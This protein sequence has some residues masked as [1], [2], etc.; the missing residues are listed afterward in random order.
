MLVVKTFITITTTIIIT[1][2]SRVA[3][4]TKFGQPAAGTCA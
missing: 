4:M 3:R 2:K 1:R